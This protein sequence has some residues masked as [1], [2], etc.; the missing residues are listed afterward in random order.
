M[1]AGVLAVSSEAPARVLLVEDD[2]HDRGLF[3][4]VLRMAGHDVASVGDG[5]MAAQMI[6]RETFHVVVSDLSLPGLDGL[7]LLQHIHA[8]DP[9]LPVILVTGSPAVES[10]AAAVELRAL[11]YLLKPLHAGTLRDVVAQ[12]IVEYRGHMAEK[13]AQDLRPLA[14]AFESALPS[15]QMHF[16]PIVSYGKKEVFAYEALVRPTTREITNPGMLFDVATR[17]ERIVDLGRIIRSKVA[18]AM[19][20]APCQVFLNLHPFELNDEELYSE[21]SV[22]APY[23]NRLVL[24]IT[25][26]AALEEIDDVRNRMARLRQLGFRLAVDDLGAGYAGLTSVAQLEPEVVKLDMALVRDVH[27]QPTKQHLIRSMIGLFNNLGR[28]VI[29]EGVESEEEAKTLVE[30]GCD[31]LQGYLFARPT[32]TFEPARF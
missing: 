30:L 27:R 11:R 23:A 25:E 22:L 9:F 14:A 15:L 16:Q 10:A 4:R 5:T 8:R 2:A 3:E 1:R 6:D 32:K 21:R 29:A 7:S 12:A 20:H 31:L 24:E 17:L 18:E 19:A 28:L 13:G 26:R